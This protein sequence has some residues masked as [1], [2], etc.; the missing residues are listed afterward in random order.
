MTRIKRIPAVLWTSLLVLAG[1]SS[2]VVGVYLLCGIAVA[3]I[4]GGVA[5]AA[6]G[7]LV[8]A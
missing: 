5:A 1:V 3:L 4:V 8:D 2:A 7:L 6:V